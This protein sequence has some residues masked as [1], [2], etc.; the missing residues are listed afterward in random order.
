MISVDA[1]RI[2][3][4][5][6]TEYDEFSAVRLETSNGSVTLYLPIGTSEAVA[7]CINVAVAAGQNVKPQ[8][9][10]L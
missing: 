7:A 2:L 5:K 6:A 3:R 4:A 8:E 10:A 1:H 9:V